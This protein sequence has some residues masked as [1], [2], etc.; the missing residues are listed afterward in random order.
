MSVQSET[1]GYAE[2]CAKSHEFVRRA[3]TYTP[4]NCSWAGDLLL[5][6]D[7]VLKQSE[8]NDIRGAASEITYT[9]PSAGDGSCGGD[10]V[11]VGPGYSVDET[12]IRVGGVNTFSFNVPK[13]VNP[14]DE[15]NWNL[16][17]LQSENECG[18]M[19][20]GGDILY[21]QSLEKKVTSLCGTVNKSSGIFDAQAHYLDNRKSYLEDTD[22]GLLICIRTG[23]VWNWEIRYSPYGR[24]T[25]SGL[26]VSDNVTTEFTAA[27]SALGMTHEDVIEFGM[28]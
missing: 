3:C 16:G 25:T 13:S 8:V 6:T 12:D 23:A 26:I 21:A 17:I 1:M 14:D 5:T 18:E 22:N 19:F 24:D 11:R 10:F 2:K 15:I 7:V 28:I 9:F 20:D 27:L 4:T